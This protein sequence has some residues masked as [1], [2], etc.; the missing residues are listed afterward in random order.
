[1][2]FI[3]FW[4]L[5]VLVDVVVDLLLGVDVGVFDGLEVLGLLDWEGGL[6]LMDVSVG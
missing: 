3:S 2:L 4:M 5:V 6:F 1:M